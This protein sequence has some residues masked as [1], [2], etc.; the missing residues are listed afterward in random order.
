MV[1][2]CNLTDVKVNGV[3]FTSKPVLKLTSTNISGKIT[4]NNVS[5]EIEKF[6]TANSFNKNHISIID[7]LF[8]EAQTN[9]FEVIIEGV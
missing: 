6:K 7:N 2:Y 5:S 9:H 3:D 8:A 1:L 4:S